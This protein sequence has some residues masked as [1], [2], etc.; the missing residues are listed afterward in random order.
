MIKNDPFP[1]TAYER[2]ATGEDY[3]YIR[4][5]DPVKDLELFPWMVKIMVIDAKK[6]G[7][8]KVCG[9]SIISKDRVLTSAH[10]FYDEEKCKL[11]NK[12]YLTFLTSFLDTLPLNPV[13]PSIIKVLPMG[14][15][16]MER[17]VKEVKFH[18]EY[19]HSPP[20]NDIAILTLDTMIKFDGDM[21]PICLPSLDTDNNYENKKA[22]AMGWGETTTEGYQKV[23]MKANVTVNS[24]N[25]NWEDRKE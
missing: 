18:E 1:K 13:D 2:A 21:S 7:G 20:E 9:G 11:N 14:D 8:D 6:G 17:G 24:D 12:I 10:C 4:N 15:K 22:F 19:K 23:L 25:C 3:D 16:D 5:G